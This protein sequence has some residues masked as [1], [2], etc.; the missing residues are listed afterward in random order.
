MPTVQ[1]SDVLHVVRELWG[2][3]GA[4][5]DDQAKLALAEAL[6]KEA[7]EHNNKWVG[8]TRLTTSAVLPAA[9]ATPCSAWHTNTRNCMVICHIQVMGHPALQALAPACVGASPLML[10][11]VSHPAASGRAS[12]STMQAVSSRQRWATSG[13]AHKSDSPKVRLLTTTAAAAAAAV[14][15]TGSPAKP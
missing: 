1:R 11:A 3:K 2:F 10:L 12:K 4:P 5:V 9:S 7:W 14:A 13:S 8:P 6:I 15:A